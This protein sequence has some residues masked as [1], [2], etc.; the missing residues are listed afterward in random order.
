MQYLLTQEEYQELQAAAVAR[1]DEATQTIQTLCT[2][3]AN[4]IPVSVIDGKPWG[5]IITKKS[6]LCDGC[7]V[8]TMCP[9]KYKRWSK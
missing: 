9:Y 1:S 4:Q 5:C 7:P 2:L 6:G 3:A 8:E